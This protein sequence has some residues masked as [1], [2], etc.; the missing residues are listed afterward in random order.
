MTAA[1]VMSIFM[2][3][4]RTK[5]ISLISTALLR[6]TL[7]VLRGC[8]DIYIYLTLYNAYLYST[9]INQYYY[10]GSPHLKIL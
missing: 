3:N 9:K 7:H 1:A 6:I 2:K 8:T 10:F 4:I 5:I